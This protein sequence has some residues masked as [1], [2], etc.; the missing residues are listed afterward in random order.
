MEALDDFLSKN[1]FSFKDGVYSNGDCKVIIHEDHYE[2]RF[3][4]GQEWGSMY[5]KDLIIYWLIGVLTWNDLID[6]NYKQ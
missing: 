3:Q 4:H 1:G 6:K 5:S 2:V